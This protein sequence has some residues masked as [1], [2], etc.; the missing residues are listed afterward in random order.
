MVASLSPFGSP[1]SI[2]YWC[3]VL[4]CFGPISGMCYFVSDAGDSEGRV[5]GSR[6]SRRL[7]QKLWV[8]RPLSV[9]LCLWEHF[10]EPRSHAD[11]WLYGGMVYGGGGG[12]SEKL[13]PK[14]A[15]HFPWVKVFPPV[16]YEPFSYPAGFLISFSPERCCTLPSCKADL[17]KVRPAAKQ[18]QLY[19]H[20]N[21]QKNN[22]TI[23]KKISP[24]VL[25]IKSSILIY[26]NNLVFNLHKP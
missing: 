2:L 1:A 10:S 17:M 19:L 6:T 24:C 3:H 26:W 21:R 16:K 5:S 12:V 23:F 18:E 25:F 15:M 22:N 20:T 4:A 11:K 13:P 14:V 8:W 9:S 7:R